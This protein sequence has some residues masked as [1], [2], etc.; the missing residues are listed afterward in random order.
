MSICYAVNYLLPCL[1]QTFHIQLKD[2]LKSL[3]F[4]TV[5]GELSRTMLFLL[6]AAVVPPPGTPR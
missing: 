2:V 3:S 6:S 5:V 4:L 1:R